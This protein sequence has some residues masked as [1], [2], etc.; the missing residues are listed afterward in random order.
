[1]WSSSL[2]LPEHWDYRSARPYSVPHAFLL[3]TRDCAVGISF[4][5][6]KRGGIGIMD[7][8]ILRSL[9]WMQ[10]LTAQSWTSFPGPRIPVGQRPG[11]QDK[12]REILLC[13]Q[14]T[15]RDPIPH[16]RAPL[17]CPSVP[18]CPHEGQPVDTCCGSC[19]SDLPCRSISGCQ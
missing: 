4:H 7:F 12:H 9:P 18:R 8:L 5:L 13:L 14:A 19:L 16:P 15:S 6:P 17:P 1:M 2:S 10:H 3:G 11:L